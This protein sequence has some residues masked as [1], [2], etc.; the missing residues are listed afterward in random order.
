M[1]MDEVLLTVTIVDV[2]QAARDVFGTA[3]PSLCPY[4]P[5]EHDYRFQIVDD[6]GRCTFGR[7]WTADMVIASWKANGRQ[8]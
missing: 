4:G 2:A 5:E 8:A 3:A 1:R 6:N 7:G